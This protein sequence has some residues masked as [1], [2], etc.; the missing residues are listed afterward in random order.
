[1]NALR[2]VYG[3]PDTKLRMVYNGVDT[4]FW[5]KENI[6]EAERQQRRIAHGRE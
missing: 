4:E 3:I 2:L 5:N 6:Q 1:M